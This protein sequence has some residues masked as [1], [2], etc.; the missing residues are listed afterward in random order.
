[1]NMR[2]LILGMFLVSCTLVKNEKLDQKTGDVFIMNYGVFI[3]RKLILKGEKTYTSY[4][5]SYFRNVLPGRYEL[6]VELVNDNSRISLDTDLSSRK[7]VMT[8]LVVS[9]D[10]VTLGSALLHCEYDRKEKWSGEK[11]PR[12]LMNTSGQLEGRIEHFEGFREAFLSKEKSYLIISLAG[13]IGSSLNKY[14]AQTDSLGKF[15]FN[16][17]K[18]GIYSLVAASDRIGFRSPDIINIVI[19]PD[20]T[21]IVNIPAS[22]NINSS[23]QPE[24]RKPC[25]FN[26]VYWQKDYQ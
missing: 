20:K 2:F 16:H 9:A 1:M 14:K 4:D 19:L 17:V 23:V 26:F 3:K 7:S 5:S 22:E 25:G 6:E 21:A 13:V 12:H 18:P 15:T 11:I 24:V 8:D 10:F